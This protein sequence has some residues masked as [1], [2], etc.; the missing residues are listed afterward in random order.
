[1]NILKNHIKECLFDLIKN[2][3]EGFEEA[4]LQVQH[5]K[6][7]KYANILK[8]T[9]QIIYKTQEFESNSL[10]KIHLHFHIIDNDLLDVISEYVL[11]RE[12]IFNK[13]RDFISEDLNTKLNAQI[14]SL[15]GVEKRLMQCPQNAR[16]K[17]GGNKI[18]KNWK[19]E[20]TIIKRRLSFLKALDSN[21]SFEV[22]SLINCQVKTKNH[23]SNYIEVIPYAN[24]IENASIGYNFINTKLT[25]EDIDRENSQLID[26]LRTII[27]YDCERK[28]VM[29][30]FNSEILN[31]WNKNY[32]TKFNRLIII[33]FSKKNLSSDN[34]INR[35]KLVK[36]R[37]NI[38][39]FESYPI[40]L[41]EYT[42][43]K[44]IQKNA[45]TNIRFIGNSYSTFWE[46][47][48]LECKSNELY[49]LRSIKM[50]NVY[51]LCYNNQIKEYILEHIFTP[52]V[53]SQLISE[54][55]KAD[56]LDLPEDDIV[57]LRNSLINVLDII[58]L[59]NLKNT[60]SD[61]LDFDYKIVLDG[62]IL[63]SESF[64]SLIKNSL[65]VNSNGKFID[66]EKLED[67]NT[68]K[69]I[70][71]S[72]RDQGNFNNHFYPNINEI[73][74]SYNTRL[75]CI[76]PALF[77]EQ[78]YKWSKYN[79]V[80]S[81][82]KA[83]DHPIRRS[84][85]E[86]DNLQEK[87]QNLKPKKRL[88]I[89][90]DLESN[91]SGS[92][93]RITFKV[94]FENNK[95]N[96]C[97]PS[98]LM[99]YFE[100]ANSEKRIQPIKWIYQNL[101]LDENHLYVQKLDE[102]IDEFN[103]A[104]KLVDTAQQEKDLEILRNQFDL[105]DD[106]VGRLWKILLSRKVA[107]SNEEVVY[108]DLKSLFSRNNIN[109]VKQSYFESTWTNPESESLVPRRNKAFK[110]LCNYLELPTAYLRIIYTIRNSNI[111]GRRNATRIYSRILKNLFNDGCFDEEAIQGQILNNRIDYYKNNFSLDEL[112]IDED[113]PI[114]GLKTLVDLLK[115]EISKLSFREVKNIQKR[116][117]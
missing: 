52:D 39:S 31:N 108:N 63:K 100:E 32:E 26:E 42:L 79:L 83:L 73:S 49:E 87:I 69:I 74:V 38:N 18:Y 91:Y 2:V 110:V 116:V 88:D 7:D 10:N 51:S 6:K 94:L 80:K 114:E 111:S 103:P 76:F 48:Q 33:T 86:W 50:M 112:G 113:N 84:D 96:T 70:I 90:W 46:D 82:F 16:A 13:N 56:I 67:I 57:N 14:K 106:N 3:N 72:Y 68:E 21:S 11:V 44:A 34:L 107:E 93:S 28:R 117:E 36:E 55:S 9:E 45:K 24:T 81:Y 43:L 102:L 104:E 22:K 27:L 35:L 89:S 105:K 101:D 97:N 41:E 115:P 85:F 8:Y 109:M 95:H 37:F 77:F 23:L 54:D 75:K 15:N 59:E 40:L 62:S 53:N 71:L 61:V 1:M 66:W 25:L 12:Y 98:D 30:N 47:F 92:D 78:T 58:I 17:N 5:P 19:K 4:F 65:N 29:Q 20:K 64:F 60:V 99:I